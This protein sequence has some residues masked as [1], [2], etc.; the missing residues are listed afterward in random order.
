MGSGDSAGAHLLC[1][2]GVGSKYLHQMHHVVFNVKPNSRPG[3]QIWFELPQLV[4]YS[5]PFH[6]SKPSFKRAILRDFQLRSFRQ[7]VPGV[8]H[9][10]KDQ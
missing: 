3:S 5:I 7:K 1:F 10:R 6:K 8:C 9:V 2:V 4:A